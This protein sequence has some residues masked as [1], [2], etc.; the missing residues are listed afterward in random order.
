M[1]VSEPERCVIS[2]DRSGSHCSDPITVVT[3]TLEYLRGS[4]K[5][6]RAISAIDE[7]GEPIS[8]S[9]EEALFAEYMAAHGMDE[10]GR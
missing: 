2:V 3:V 1:P 6:W 7:T 8:L 9:Q 5:G 4:F 10:T